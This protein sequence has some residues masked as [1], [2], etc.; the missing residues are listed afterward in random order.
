MTEQPD[1][2]DRP[3]DTPATA[4]TP[5]GPVPTGPVPP[6]T[7][8]ALS[9]A[10]PP[11]AAAPPFA[12]AP[13]PADMVWAGPELTPPAARRKPRAATVLRWGGALLLLAA[14]GTATAFAVTTP[15]RTDLPGLATPNDGRYTFAP[16][17]LPQL[18]SGKSAPSVADPA[19]RHYADLRRLVLQPPNGAVTSAPTATPAASTTASPSPSPAA[20][21]ASPAAG[22]GASTSPSPAGSPASGSAHTP[23]PASAADC[24]DYA[25]LDTPSSATAVRLAVNGCRTA[26]TRVWTAADGTRTEI[27]LL[28]FG[29]SDEAARCYSDLTTNAELNA[30]PEAVSTDDDFDFSHGV[31]SFPRGSRQKS[32]DGERLLGK[33]VYLDEGDTLV[34]VL[35]T[36][37][38]GVADQAF[39]QVV[40]LQS[41]LLG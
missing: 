1:Q 38:N 30:I 41:D 19:G 9:A 25:R 32:A 23:P 29:S 12:A 22:A 3:A 28:R 26:A 16:L 40:T 14:T 8:P 4:P 6:P 21:S 11:P 24:A 20:A 39:R 31:Q 13:P 34:T 35:M 15:P 27:W 33:V 10:V 5:T 2:T 37:P 18:P 17:A 36:N 7:A